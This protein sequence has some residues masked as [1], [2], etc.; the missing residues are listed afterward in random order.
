MLNPDF[1]HTMQNDSNPSALK[2]RT[3]M[4]RREFM[5]LVAAVPVLTI[6]DSVTTSTDTANFNKFIQLSSILTGFS[7]SEFDTSRASTLFSLLMK[8][9]FQERL[10]SALES[11]SSETDDELTEVIVTFWYAGIIAIDGDVSV[12]TYVDGLIWTTAWFATPKTICSPIPNDWSLPP[13]EA[14]S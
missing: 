7:N 3:V 8:S 13:S 9:N 2:H 10:I 14:A 6:S 5:A 1:H 12:D 4:S 11:P